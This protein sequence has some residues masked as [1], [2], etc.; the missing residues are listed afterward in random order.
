MQLLCVE[1][2]HA[3]SL[4]I[5]EEKYK[6]PHHCAFSANDSAEPVDEDVIIIFFSYN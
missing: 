1:T 6:F 4:R 3:P 2:G 5:T